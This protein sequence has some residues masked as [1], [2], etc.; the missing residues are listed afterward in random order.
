MSVFKKISALIICAVL[1]CSMLASCQPET[2]QGNDNTD[3]PSDKYV[4]T[5]TI[6]YT[7]MDAKLKEAVEAMGTPTATIYAD[8]ENVKLESEV[9]TDSVTAISGYTLIDGTLYHNSRVIVG[10][11]AVSS[12]EKAA[13]DSTARE[14]LIE[15]IGPG[16]SIGVE[17]FKFSG[18]TEENGAVKY[19]CY[20][21]ADEA[22]AS[23][24]EIFGA[25]LSALD[26][27]VA[28]D[29]ANYEVTVA[30]GR[31]VSSSLVCNFIVTMDDKNYSVIMRVSYEYDYDT[32]VSISAPS[33][34]DMYK[35]VSAEEI[36]G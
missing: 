4:A 25:Q 2:D 10:Y 34:A 20:N 9:K 16:A 18:S 19:T 11:L 30:H 32:E 24:I 6:K 33:D 7:A 29:S 36:L 27:T 5:V 1:L 23:L 21:I 12:R 31:E 15:N 35:E 13:V 22:K 28:I 8:G 3:L 17:D 14:E 26:A